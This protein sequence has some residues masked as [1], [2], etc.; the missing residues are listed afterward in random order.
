M[1]GSDTGLLRVDLVD[2]TGL[3]AADRSGSSDPYAV[4][5]L[6]GEKLFKSAVQKRTLKPVCE[7]HS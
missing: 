1:S 6:G 2:A 7:S 3:R 5:E 4:F